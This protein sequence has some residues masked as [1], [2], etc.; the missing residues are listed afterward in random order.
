[1]VQPNS[2]CQRPLLCVSLTYAIENAAAVACKP[3]AHLVV[4]QVKV[5]NHVGDLRLGGVGAAGLEQRLGDVGLVQQEAAWKGGR[6]TQPSRRRQLQL[7]DTLQ[8]QRM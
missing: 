1:M 7:V 2:N 6:V 8:Q 4:D 3:Q 5:A